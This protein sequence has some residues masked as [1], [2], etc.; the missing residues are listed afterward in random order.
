MGNG[1]LLHTDCD[2]D[3]YCNPASVC[4]LCIACKD[5]NTTSAGNRES[6]EVPK[7][8]TSWCAGW[9]DFLDELN[10]LDL[11]N[12]DGYSYGYEYA[13]GYEY[14][15]GDGDPIFRVAEDIPADA[16]GEDNDGSSN[17]AAGEG[18]CNRATGVGCTCMEPYCANCITWGVSRDEQMCLKCRDGRAY[19]NGKC[20]DEC[21][22]STWA[23]DDTLEVGR[24][25]LMHA[26]AH[27][28][29][30]SDAATTIAPV[31]TSPQLPVTTKQSVA[32]ASIG[33][34]EVFTFMCS[35]D[36]IELPLPETLYAAFDQYLVRLVGGSGLDVI[37]IQ[38]A[39]SR[40]LTVVVE[41]D[42]PASRLLARHIDAEQLE[43]RYTSPDGSASVVLNGIAGSWDLVEDLSSLTVLSQA[44]TMPPAVA[45]TPRGIL[46]F[47]H[48]VLVDEGA[49][50]TTDDDIR[51]RQTRSNMTVVMSSVGFALAIG[52]GYFIYYRRA[53]N[54]SVSF[55][56]RRGGFGASLQNGIHQM[57]MEEYATA[58][59]TNTHSR[60]TIERR[61]GPQHSRSRSPYRFADTEIS[62]AS[63]VY[64]ARLDNLMNNGIP[65]PPPRPSL[66]R[67]AGRSSRGS[68]RFGGD[69]H[70]AAQGIGHP[71]DS[72]ETRKL[73]VNGIISP[74]EEVLLSSALEAIR[75]PLQRSPLQPQPIRTQFGITTPRFDNVS[76]GD[77][78]TEYNSII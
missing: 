18:A 41:A 50:G 3:S 76:I 46:T 43:Y 52:L 60:H 67:S 1:C 8:C 63:A 10:R 14:D 71:R 17:S 23:N 56:K 77:A 27:S 62:R 34:K 51:A 55:D 39:A 36:V 53:R 47:T 19:M 7:Q 54:S 12:N 30:T 64:Q 40:Q 32:I 31:V 25:C 73:L 4:S 6:N 2:A 57:E 69:L 65:L 22:L 49:D 9:L 48:S 68:P 35:A 13:N 24:E 44:T 38:S 5:E 66:Y 70:G 15:D 33:K 61:Q 28:S 42:T 58:G 75:S 74:N 21:P 59:N 29:P 78:N 11:T 26:A 37:T 20:L 72:F 45:S 16:N